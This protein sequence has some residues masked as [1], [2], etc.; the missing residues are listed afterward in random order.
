MHL[1]LSCDGVSEADQQ[2]WDTRYREG[3]Y[4]ARTNPSALLE[5]W[6]PRLAGLGAP[7]RAVDVACGLGRNALYLARQGWQVDAVDIS[8]VAL[9]ALAATATVEGLPIACRQLDLERREQQTALVSAE[10]YDL[11]LL[12]RYTDLA[13]IEI[14]DRALRAGGYLIAEEHLITDADVI[15]PSSP[16]FRVAPG[17]LRKAARGLEIKTYREGIVT[18]PDGRM[19]ALAQLVARKPEV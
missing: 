9:Q 2:K 19:A 3:A 18:D 4:Q 10:P 15:G 6:L 11:A 8:A 16:R 13:L 14:L 12:V 7:A 5:E 1:T 17:Q